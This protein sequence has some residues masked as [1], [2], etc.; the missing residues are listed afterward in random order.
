MRGRLPTIV[1]SLTGAAAVVIILQILAGIGS[2]AAGDTERVSVNS[3]GQQATGTIGSAYPSLSA[4]GRFVAFNSSA[5]N[6]VPGDT[7][8]LPDVF[9]RDRQAGTT[10]LESTGAG[11]DNANS[12]SGRPSISADGRFVVFDS[13]VVSGPN[14]QSFHIWIH[15]RTLGTT[16]PVTHGFAPLSTSQDAA[17]SAD[18]RFVAFWSNG[19][20]A[21]TG[22]VPTQVMVWDREHDTME[23]VSVDGNGTPGDGNSG[24]PAISAD[25]RFVAFMSESTNLVA[26]DT[27]GVPDIF[28]HDRQTG[29]TERVSVDSS[30]GQANGESGELKIL[31]SVFR[32]A[33]GISADGRFVAFESQADNLVS[34]DTNSAVDVF[35]H[36][37]QTGTT[38]RVS[39]DSTGTQANGASSGNFRLGVS[40][41]GRFIAFQSMATNLVPGDTNGVQDVFVRDRQTASTE[42]DSVDSAGVEENGQSV[43]MT[44]ISADG[45]FVGFPSAATNLV[46]DDT[47]GLQDVFVHDRGLV[48]TPT[49]S[50]TPSP[51]PTPT[52][53][54]R[55][56]GDDDCSGDIGPRDAQS[57]LKNVLQ[58]PPLSQ[59]QPCPAVGSTVTVDGVSRMWG[60]TDCGGDIGPRDAQGILKNVL[61]Q[62]PLSQSQ[63]CP[64]VGST[65][66]VVG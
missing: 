27:N 63:P 57:I 34:G 33:P 36:D 7:N 35:V 5:T 31:T 65:V 15:D 54:S 6:L 55:I 42:R 18:G 40:A 66:Q 2:A 22:A 49:P 43:G 21:P 12:L 58:Q 19:P 10:E 11:F 50:P 1:G 61:Q 52:G 30:G 62:P 47:N 64:A 38:E 25:G 29:T 13:E 37:R 24:P 46:Q 17:I 28:V 8:N 3:S 44:Q 56:W 14:Q 48:A 53:T 20:N 16:E 59:T 23:T 32:L 41:D 26:G 39:V 60:D 45:R 4:D 51:T 9:V